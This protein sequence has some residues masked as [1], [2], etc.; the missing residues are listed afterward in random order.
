MLDAQPNRGAISMIGTSW[1]DTRGIAQIVP[2]FDGNGW[3]AKEKDWHCVIKE[4]SHWRLVYLDENLRISDNITSSRIVR[5]GVKSQN[6]L[7]LL[8]NRFPIPFIGPL[9]VKRVST[10]AHQMPRRVSSPHFKVAPLC[11]IRYTIARKR[12]LRR[13]KRTS[14][15]LIER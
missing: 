8:V 9:V 11:S 3:E 14:G 5:N 15:T 2:G 4:C 12:L 6:H 10:L 1:L 13:R 7:Q